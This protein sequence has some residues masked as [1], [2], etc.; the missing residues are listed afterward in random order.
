M[1]L[2]VTSIKSGFDV[3]AWKTALGLQLH[4]GG[5]SNS[6]L[7]S[8]G[9]Q[10]GYEIARIPEIAGTELCG[11]AGFVWSVGAN[12]NDSAWFHVDKSTGSLRVDFKTQTKDWPY[13]VH[14]DGIMAYS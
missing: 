2:S 3:K 10:W 11:L 13:T 8:S 7:I 1:A 14:C 4:V 9:E 5:S 12:Y 6:G